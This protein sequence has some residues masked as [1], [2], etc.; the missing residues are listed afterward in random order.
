MRILKFTAAAALAVSLMTSAASAETLRFAFQGTLNQLDPYSLNETFTLSSQGNIYEGLTRRGPDL[1][2][3]PALAESWEIMEPNRWR[4][5]LRKGVKFHNG[6][7]FNADDVVFSADRVRSEG[8]DLTSRINADVKV[9]KIDDYTV[10]FLLPGPN[11]ILHYEWDTWYIMDKEWTEEHDAVKV[12]SASDTT[13]NFA[14]LHANGTGP[15]KL[16]SHEPGIRTI[17]E[18]NDNW[19]DQNQGN[20]DRVEFT[21]IASDA[22][23]VAALLSGE[24]DMVYPIPVQDVQR[25]ESNAT[26]SAMTGP[27]L[28]T[29]FLGMDQHRDELTDSNV[30]GKNPFKDVRVR[31]AFYQAINMDAIRDKVMRGMSNPTSLLI[32]PLLYSRSDEFERYPYDPEASKKLLAEAGYP[33]GFSVTMDCPND[34]YVNDEAIC[35][36]VAAF[37]ARVGVKINLNAQPKAQYFAKVLASNNYNTSF[38][39]LGWTP[40]SFDSWN[41]L[42]NIT[43]CRDEKGKGGPFNLG[44]YCSKEVDALAAEILKENDK[45][46]RDDL[47]AQAFTILHNEVSHIPLHQQ[48]L[49]WGVSDKLSL[50]QRA[51]NQFI[52]RW[53]VKK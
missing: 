4:F 32:S 26:T 12:N 38:Y 39:L 13:P 42:H 15:Y 2:I 37:L 14:T 29:I 27:E 7:D 51:D 33:D 16:V 46:K 17:Y 43:G 11:P 47:I 3:E 19:W 10:D 31:K 6:N 53:V 52:F 1:A 45:T 48:S 30:K 23:R 50:V 40:S 21:P 18:R 49:A 35:Q 22:T 5:H 36:T 28:R 44:G 41:V 34:R 20:I 24:L 25:V 9:E 8:S